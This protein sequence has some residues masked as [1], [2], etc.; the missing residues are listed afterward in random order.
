MI[1]VIDSLR[2]QELEGWLN[3]YEALPN[4]VVVQEKRWHA[5]KRW[6]QKKPRF[7][8]HEGAFKGQIGEGKAKSAPLVLIR[9]RIKSITNDP[10]LS[11]I[12][13]CFC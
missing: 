4:D 3:Q 2:N 8:A 12:K 7:Q 5:M 6:V 9:Q 13:T 10:E 11:L 1:R